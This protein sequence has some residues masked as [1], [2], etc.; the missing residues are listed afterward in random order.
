MKSLEESIA[1]AMDAENTEIFP[2]LQDILQDFWEIGASPADM[3]ALIEKHS[4]NYD[5]LKI[6]DL[7]CGKG[8]VSIKIAEKLHCECLGIDGIKEFIEYADKKAIE[9]KVEHLCQFEQADIREKINELPTFDVI[10]LGAIGQVFGNYYETLTKLKKCLKTGGLILIDDAYIEDS[11]EFS[12]SALLKKS[13]LLS[14]VNEANMEVI[15]ELF[16][17][18]NEN[19][20]LHEREFNSLKQRCDELAEKYP[21]KKSLFENYVQ[22]QDEEYDKLETKM[23]CLTMAIRAK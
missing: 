22:K 12:H 17:N 15:D 13:E 4:E 1:T 8:A 7:G 2:Y 19:T 11:S 14:Q 3:I 9:Y 16:P 5:T 20:E 6:L 23:I 21:E 18:E 10:I